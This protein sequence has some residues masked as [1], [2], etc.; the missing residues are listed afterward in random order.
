MSKAWNMFDPEVTKMFLRV[1]DADESRI[2][3]ERL[4]SEAADSYKK[5]ALYYMAKA[6]HLEEQLEDASAEWIKIQDR[7]E[8][9]EDQVAEARRKG[10]I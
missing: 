6:M 9:L 4:R 10:A 7:I 3:A 8:E 2:L 1:Q 5:Q